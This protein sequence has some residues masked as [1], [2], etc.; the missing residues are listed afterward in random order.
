MRTRSQYN[1]NN[2]LVST[3][4]TRSQ[5]NK[6]KN[7]SMDEA[8]TTMRTRSYYNKKVGFYLQP[9]ESK[10]YE[11]LYDNDIDFDG[12]SKAWNSNKRK[13]SDGCYQYI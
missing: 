7:P 1:Q 4:R 6:S 9:S 11:Q 5:T 13:L 8:V 12:A 3:M 10:T 2:E